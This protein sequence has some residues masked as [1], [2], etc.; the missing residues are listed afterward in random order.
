VRHYSGPAGL[1]E[2]SWNLSKAQNEFRV[3][4]TA[5]VKTKRDVA[6]ARR[7]REQ[8]AAHGL[9][10]RYLTNAEKVTLKEVEPMDPAY[11]QY[12]HVDPMTL[13]ISCDMYIYNDVVTLVNYA[14]ATATEITHPPLSLMLRQLFDASWMAAT[15]LQISKK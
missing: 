6:F 3:F 8:Y 1:K 10:A 4:E 15:A 5:Q 7:C 14:R 11:V 2:V 9:Y 12:R 13:S